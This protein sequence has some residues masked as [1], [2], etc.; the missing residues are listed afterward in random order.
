[1]YPYPPVVVYWMTLNLYMKFQ[2]TGNFKVTQYFVAIV[3]SH[4]QWLEFH[5]KMHG[6]AGKQCVLSAQKAGKR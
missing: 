5:I 4:L 6:I 3:G 2:Y 1:M